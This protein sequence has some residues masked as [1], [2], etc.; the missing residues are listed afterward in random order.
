MVGV[1][2]VGPQLVETVSGSAHGDQ[3]CDE[4]QSHTSQPGILGLGDT[5]TG[6]H[7]HGDVEHSAQSPGPHGR[8][9]DPAGQELGAAEVEARFTDHVGGVDD[10]VRPR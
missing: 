2:Q 10:Q 9:T 8:D 6:Q 7:R 3:C 4:L 5:A 1:R